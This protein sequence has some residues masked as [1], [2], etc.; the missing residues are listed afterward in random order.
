[1]VHSDWVGDTDLQ[2]VGE[3]YCTNHKELAAT[4]SASQCLGLAKADTECVTGTTISWGKGSRAGRCL[5]DL[6][7]DCTLE[8]N[9]LGADGYD[10]FVTTHGTTSGSALRTLPPIHIYFHCF[11]LRLLLLLLL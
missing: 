6:E 10:R 3:G 5:C 9:G 1:M 8:I 7:E 2:D 11:W 4:A